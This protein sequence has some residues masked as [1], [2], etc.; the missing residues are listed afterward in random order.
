MTRLSLTSWQLIAVA[1]VI[2]II[3]TSIG[4]FLTNLNFL[5]LSNVLNQTKQAAEERNHFELMQLAHERTTRAIENATQTV[6]VILAE[7]LKT[8]K[9]IA[10]LTNDVFIMQ[11]SEL[12]QRKT[13]GE[14]LAIIAANNNMT[15]PDELRK[16]LF[17]ETTTPQQSAPDY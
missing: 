11:K 17:I 1:I 16:R 10:E 2:N 7:M 13:L 6:A 15:I 9:N 14:F 12:E 5:S 4:V 8:Q 3:V